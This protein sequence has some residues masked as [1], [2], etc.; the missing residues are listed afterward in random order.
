[1]PSQEQIPR[2]DGPNIE[3]KEFGD[4]GPRL[5]LVQTVTAQGTSQKAQ[6]FIVEVAGS[7]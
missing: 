1:M 4:S 7:D 5:V 6:D 2:L 3:D